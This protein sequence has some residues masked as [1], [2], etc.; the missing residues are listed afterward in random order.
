MALFN[1]PIPFE[2]R[3]GGY[4]DLVAAGLVAR[5]A[6]TGTA[7]ASETAALE[8]AA[9]QWAGAMA[10]ARVEPA[11]P[12]TA[13]LTPDV[14]QLA[15]REAIR[16]GAA[17]F[18]IDVDALTGRVRLLPV[19][20]WDVYG[21]VDPESWWYRVELAGPNGSRTRTIPAAGVVFLPFATDPAAPWRGLSPMALARLTGNLAGNLETRLGQESGAPVGSVI[22]VP[23]DGGDGGETDPLADL[24]ADLRA[25]KGG[26]SLVETTAAGF[27]EGRQAAPAQDWKPRRYGA[28][29]PETLRG[30]RADVYEAV[31]AAC[32]VPPQLAMGQLDGTLARESWRRFVMGRVEPLARTWAGELAGKLDAPGLSFSFA[33]LWAHDFAGRAQ[34]FAKLVG[35]GMALEKAAAVSG[36][37]SDAA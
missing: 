1:S 27:G 24:K 31:C 11:T 8:I 7:D 13:A 15:G 21:G 4:T 22:P 23:T 5:A 20:A 16:R 10:A 3:E 14:L 33:A 25:S 37:L 34:A 18:V 19:W 6:G 32:G 26:L 35:A 17:L 36:V 28:D 30:L 9:G 12:A 29:P 2:K